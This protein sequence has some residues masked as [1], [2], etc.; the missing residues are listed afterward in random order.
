[1]SANTRKTAQKIWLLLFSLILLVISFPTV[2]AEDTETVRIGVIFPNADWMSSM[3]AAVPLA[4]E[5]INNYMVSNGYGYRFE[6]VYKNAEGNS[7][8][9]LEKQI[10]L[11]EEGIDLV[12]GCPWSLFAE[13]SVPYA[14][15]N[16]MLIISASSNAP[17]LS[18]EGDNLF[19]LFPTGLN[20]AS[21]EI[22][23]SQGKKK[24]AL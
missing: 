23:W 17:D 5:D 6:F 24:P 12:I 9:H 10:E 21:A 7:H 19:R 3:G 13:L 16:D 1:M 20:P 14:N 8:T 4:E 11:K 18:I 2:H 22:I 15:D